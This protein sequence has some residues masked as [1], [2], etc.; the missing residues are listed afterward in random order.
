MYKA[1]LFP[2]LADP[3]LITTAPLT[4]LVPALEV[5]K[6]NDP[7]APQELAPVKIEIPPP[8]CTEL[9]PADN[10]IAPPDPLLPL[11]T[12]ITTDPPR[13]PTAEPV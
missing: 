9:N 5:L 8:V 6:C 13:P 7:L 3:V 10:V 1:P 2:L 4:P 11:P 12:E